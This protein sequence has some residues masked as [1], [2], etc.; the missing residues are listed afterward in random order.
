MPRRSVP[1]IVYAA[2]AAR[3]IKITVKIPFILQLIM[4][5]VGPHYGRSVTHII[6]ALGWVSFGTVLIKIQILLFF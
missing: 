5:I 4:I 3:I 1:C 6:T 2:T